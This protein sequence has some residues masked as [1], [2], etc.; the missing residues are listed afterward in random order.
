MLF[1][2]NLS[3]LFRTHVAVGI[4]FIIVFL[5]LVNHKLLFSGV[6]LLCSLLP[7]IDMSSSFLGKYKF[8]R[9]LQWVVKHRGIFH[10]FTFAI[11]FSIL[12]AF[13]YPILAL[14]FFLGYSAH[15]IADSL[16]VEGIK[17]FWPHEHEIKW[18]IRTGGKK[19]KM[20]F[21]TLMLVNVILFIKYL[22]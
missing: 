14:P 15:L 5:P 9:P 8:L 12:F 20:I 16:T 17:P 7:D 10:S 2:R 21:Y 18:K 22:T 1:H 6:V 4:F 13:Y 3:M 11:F 19:K